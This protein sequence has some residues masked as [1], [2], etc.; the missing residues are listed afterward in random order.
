M[1]FL[2][3]FIAAFLTL[4][5]CTQQSPTADNAEQTKGISQDSK[6]IETEVMRIHDEVMPKMTD[7]QHLTMQLRERKTSA[8]EDAT[9][10]PSY[11]AGLDEQ[12][13]SLK[14]AE[15]NMMDWMKNYSDQFS[16]VT[17]E[18]STEFMNGQLVKIKEVQTQMMTA[19]DGANEWL[20]KNPA[21]I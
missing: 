8:K 1:K 18:M 13:T 19:I 12:L 21:S 10:K 6:T 17:P 5:S 3:F 16:K 2:F 20:A 7:I 11:P 9:G 14:N 15:N 4:N